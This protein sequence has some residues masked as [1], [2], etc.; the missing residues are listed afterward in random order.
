MKTTMLIRHALIA[1]PLLSLAACGQASSETRSDAPLIA[2]ATPATDS[3]A[4]YRAGMTP[5][6]R[7]AVRFSEDVLRDPAQ[8]FALMERLRTEVVH[9]TRQV[10]DPRWYNELRPTLRRQL[11]QAGL[12]RADVD[13]LLKEIDQAR[14]RT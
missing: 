12:T 1:L 9:K 5:E 11:E 10:P 14:P 7:P 6:P 4:A 2:M 3:P 8:R 13:F